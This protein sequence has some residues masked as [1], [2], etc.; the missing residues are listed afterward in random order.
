LKDREKQQ[1][2]QKVTPFI[3]SL[4]TQSLLLL[5]DYLQLISGHSI[6]LG[7]NLGKLE[8]EQIFIEIWSI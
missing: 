5:I 1:Q 4:F 7:G 3:F 2:Q 6:R 8:N